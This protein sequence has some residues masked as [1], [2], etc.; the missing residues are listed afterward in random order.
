[1]SQE[2]VTSF[3]LICTFCQENVAKPEWHNSRQE[4]A[5]GWYD[6]ALHSS[7]RINKNFITINIIV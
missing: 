3:F 7:F 1:M 4:A 5:P 2:T 6:K